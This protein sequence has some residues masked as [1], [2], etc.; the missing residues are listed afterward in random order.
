MPSTEYA[1]KSLLFKLL[2]EST[3]NYSGSSQDGVLWNTVSVQCLYHTYSPI[4]LTVSRRYS[5][6]SL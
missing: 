2:V 1:Q 3:C 4:V 6:R 5:R